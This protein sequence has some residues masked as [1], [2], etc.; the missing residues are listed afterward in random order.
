MKKI[1]RGV[2][3]VFCLMMPAGVYA[4]DVTLKW[5]AN[6]ETDLRGYK[7]HYGAASRG[8]VPSP[9]SL[10]FTYDRIVDVGNVTT[11]TVKNLEEGYTFHASATAYDASGNESAYSNEVKTVVDTVAPGSP[12]T[13]TIEPKKITIIIE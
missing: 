13:L 7:I 4:G 6:T 8:D 5:D 10:T 2:L 3:F 9:H 11:Y 12:K 1:I